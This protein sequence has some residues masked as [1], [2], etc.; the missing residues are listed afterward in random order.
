MS[1]A[2]IAAQTMDPPRQGGG[3]LLGLLLGIAL[4]ALLALAVAWYVTRHSPFR[5]QPAS[6]TP[7]GDIPKEILAMV[8]GQHNPL[9]TEPNKSEPPATAP[10][11]PA[12]TP[13]TLPQ[14][15]APTTTE[16]VAPP[17]S[18]LAPPSASERWFWQVGAF[19]SEQE[20][21]RVRAE[22]ALMGV[23]SQVEP[24]RMDN[25][26]TLYRVRVGP[27]ASQQAAQTVRKRLQ[28]AGYQPVLVRG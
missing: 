15:A 11:P 8:Q 4:G 1:L 12:E 23:T 18:S 26:R 19:G 20:A 27:Y 16:P 17:Q 10:A 6:T 24:V 9:R 5:S 13:P 28:A 2:K 22:L 21:N 7:P 14:P 3:T 25:G